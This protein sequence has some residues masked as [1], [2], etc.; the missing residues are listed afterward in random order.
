MHPHVPGWPPQLPTSGIQSP[1]F[2]RASGLAQIAASTLLRIGHIANQES[3][4]VEHYMAQEILHPF[5]SPKPQ[6]SG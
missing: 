4:R 3:L 6:A 2:H 5:R 1:Y